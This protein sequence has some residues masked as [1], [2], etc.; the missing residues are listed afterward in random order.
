MKVLIAALD[1]SL[2]AKPV[3]DAAVAIAPLFGASVEAVHVGEPGGRT[4][5]AIAE[6][7]GVAFRCVGGA[8]VPAL[9]QAIAAEETVGA[10]IGARGAL[11]GPTPAGHTALAVAEEVAK[12]VVVVPPD[13]AARPREPAKIVVPLD[14]TPET[15][16]A[17]RDLVHL[18][19]GRRAEI[20]VVHVFDTRTV[21]R[22]L[23]RPARDLETLGR[24]FLER[25]C[26]EI[27][28]RF[29]WRTGSARGAVAELAEGDGN[30][31]V[32]LA[33]NGNLSS[34]HGAVVAE[35]LARA[36]IPVLLLPVSARDGVDP[37]V[38]AASPD[39]QSRS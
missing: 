11:T 25:Y 33:W 26:R 12:P 18:I 39:G 27:G 34:G 35:V 22:F 17:V 24:E 10:V 5:E 15:A 13:L 36:R 21:P 9:L 19:A 32:V 4:A 29:V 1:N 16:E 23:D 8:T 38:S 6:A 3:L 20:V 14:G 28:A 30:A 31:L 37:V 7:A 2:A